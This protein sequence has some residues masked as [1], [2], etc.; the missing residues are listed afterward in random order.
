MARYRGP[1]T[2]IARK[3]GEEI[4]GYD[5]YFQRRKYPSGQHGP[6]KRRKSQSEYSIQLQEK[7]KAKYTYG[8]LERQFA[9][10]FKKAAKKHGVTGEVLLQLLEARL[11][12]TIYRMGMANSRRQARQIVLHKHIEVNGHLVNIPSY[13]LRPGDTITVREK[14]KSLEIITNALGSGNKASS[15]LEVNPTAM[16]GR[17]IQYPNREDIPEK[18]NEQL[19]VELYS[20]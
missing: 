8:L 11:D 7:Q 20:K 4:F 16:E 17:F 10:T 18:I 2:K 6:S 19:I 14:S 3:F 9:N 5:K 1:R 12:N 13:S 15:W